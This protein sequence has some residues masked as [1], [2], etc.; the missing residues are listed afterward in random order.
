MKWTL[1]VFDYQNGNVFQS[2]AILTMMKMKETALLLC[3][4]KQKRKREN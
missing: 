4:R 2:G 1:C 3:N